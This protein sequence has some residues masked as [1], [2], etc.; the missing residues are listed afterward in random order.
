[1]VAPRAVCVATIRDE[2][3]R[4]RSP[5]IDHRNASAINQ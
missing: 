4:A 3:D 1:M 5:A 2:P